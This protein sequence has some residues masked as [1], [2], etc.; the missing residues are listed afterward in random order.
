MLENFQFHHR[1]QLLTA[2][3]GD[4]HLPQATT[5]P[6]ID[7]VLNRGSAGSN[8]LGIKGCGESGASG[9]PPAVMNAIQDALSTVLGKKA[10]AIQMP[11][12]PP[13]IWTLFNATGSAE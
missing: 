13:A 2:D 7:V 12:T 11:A 10:T 5:I 9:S 1:G 8:R 4:Y 6:H 3:F